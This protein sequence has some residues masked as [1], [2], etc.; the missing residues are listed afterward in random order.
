MKI[1]TPKKPVGTTHFV[2]FCI[3]IWEYLFN[4]NFPFIDTDTVKVERGPNGYAFKASPPGSPGQG[5][6]T[7]SDYAG[8]YVPGQTY[9]AL[10]WVDIQ[11]GVIAGA[12]ISTADNN[13]NRPETGIN[14]VQFSYLPEFF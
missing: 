2:L 10:Q 6:A 7:K 9:N 3:A 1:P 5:G 11:T 14:W 8:L 4:G 12:W 13:T